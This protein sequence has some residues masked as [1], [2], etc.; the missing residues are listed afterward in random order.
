MR[1]IERR[2]PEVEGELDRVEVDDDDESCSCSA[3][4]ASVGPGGGVGA[5]GR[6]GLHLGR[7]EPWAGV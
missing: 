1:R 6:T 5:A 4:A 3:N 7:V 2:P